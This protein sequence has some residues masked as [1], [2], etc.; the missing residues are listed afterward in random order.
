MS[1]L[2]KYLLP[3]CIQKVKETKN[4][5]IILNRNYKPVGFNILGF[6]EYETFPIQYKLNITPKIAAKLS[7]KNSMSTEEIYLYNDITNPLISNDNMKLYLERLRILSE[8]KVKDVE[9][10][11]K[12]WYNIYGHKF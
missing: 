4:E 10:S 9:E 12:P 2:G 5:Y 8:L 1:T 11:R 7:Y 6:V 3:Y